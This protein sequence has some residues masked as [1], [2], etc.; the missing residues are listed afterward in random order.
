MKIS[1]MEQRLRNLRIRYGDLP[2]RVKYCSAGGY[3][4]YDLVEEDAVRHSEKRGCIVID[5]EYN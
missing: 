1:E 5:A 3:I 4:G 2:V